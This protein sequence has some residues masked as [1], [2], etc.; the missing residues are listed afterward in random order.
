M[1]FYFNNSRE[2]PRS[3]KGMTMVEMMVTLAL[4]TIVTLGLI[5]SH[6]FGMRYDYLVCGKLGASD[7]SRVALAKLQNEIRAA[8]GYD[9]GGGSLT[10]FTDDADGTPQQ[11][12]GLKLWLSTS[13]SSFIQYY[14]ATNAISGAELRRKETGISGYTVVAES[15][16]NYV[17]T[18]IFQA[19]DY[20]NQV[21]TSSNARYLIHTTL[22]FFQYKYPKTTVGPGNYYDY[23]KLEFKTAPRVFNN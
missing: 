4:F 23:Y 13:S 19:E 21:Q 8:Q 7:Q 3:V 6:V 20:T 10:N 5:Y 15:L 12:N 2:N 11:G 1:K 22:Q 14:L 18:P 17:S 9:I 16:T